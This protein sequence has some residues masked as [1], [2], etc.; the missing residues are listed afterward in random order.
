MQWLGSIDCRC[1]SNTYAYGLGDPVSQIAPIGLDSWGSSSGPAMT[2]LAFSRSAETVTATNQN[3]TVIGAYPAGNLR[4]R[5]QRLQ[6][7][8][9]LDLGHFRI[10]H[11]ASHQ[12]T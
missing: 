4:R 3:G 5:P 1:S 11:Q 10:A 6:Y 12:R 2:N 8:G 9:Q 7:L